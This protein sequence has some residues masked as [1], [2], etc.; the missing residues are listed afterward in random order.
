[1]RAAS[2]VVPPSS[3]TSSGAAVLPATLTGWAENAFL[4]VRDGLAVADQD[5]L[6]EPD[7]AAWFD[8]DAGRCE[9]GGRLPY[10][11]DALDLEVLAGAAEACRV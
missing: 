9:L 6:P 3:L 7:V 4:Q 5:G 11:L 10:H 2:R 8:A 1:M